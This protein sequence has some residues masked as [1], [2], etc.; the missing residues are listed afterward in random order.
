MNTALSI[1]VYTLSPL[2]ILILGVFLF[3][4]FIVK[5][6]VE[7]FFLKNKEYLYV[8]N[9]YFHSLLIFFVTLV[10]FLIFC[11]FFESLIIS[12][13]PISEILISFLLLIF[14][15]IFV[16]KIIFKNSIIYITM[17]IITCF[18]LLLIMTTII[19]YTLN[20]CLSGH[21]WCF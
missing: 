9:Y 19:A 3:L 17:G 7:K 5:K 18:F 12:Y 14:A 4:S 16:R 21:G 2:I 20:S 11:I 13:E 1:I 8:G 15:E 6:L 10:L